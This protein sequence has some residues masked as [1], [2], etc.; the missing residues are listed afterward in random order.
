MTWT[1]RITP[2]ADLGEGVAM[3][4]VELARTGMTVG[5][6]T[7]IIHIIDRIFIQLLWIAVRPRPIIVGETEIEVFIPIR[8]RANEKGADRRQPLLRGLPLWLT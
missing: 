2:L 4:V 6:N 5:I 7:A 1:D 3:T 8:A